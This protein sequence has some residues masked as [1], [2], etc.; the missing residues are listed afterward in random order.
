MHTHNV[1]VD[2]IMVKWRVNAWRNVRNQGQKLRNHTPPLPSLLPTQPTMQSATTTHSNDPA[3]QTLDGPLTSNNVKLVVPQSSAIPIKPSANAH[4]CV[5]PSGSYRILQRNSNVP[6]SSA[7]ANAIVHSPLPAGSHLDSLP[8]PQPF[9]SPLNPSLTFAAL[10]TAPVHSPT[11]S[12]AIAAG[13]GASPGP[14]PSPP[15]QEP[16]LFVPLNPVVLTM[17]FNASTG[18][19]DESG[20]ML[21]VQGLSDSMKA[22][23]GPSDR[24]LRTLLDN[25]AS[26]SP[27]NAEATNVSSTPAHAIQ[28]TNV[29]EHKVSSDQLALRGVTEEVVNRGE[30]RAQG[31]GGVVGGLDLLAEAVAQA[32]RL[33]PKRKGVLVPMKRKMD[34]VGLGEGSQSRETPGRGKRSRGKQVRLGG[35]NSRSLEMSARKRERLV[36]A[37]RGKLVS[38]EAGRAIGV[39]CV[40]EL[41]VKGKGR[42]R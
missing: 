22:F 15:S 42:A 6:G 5:P 3:L 26:V 13:S 29:R 17:R 35:E 11:S 1:Q 18:N 33:E 31:R 4:L 38:D 2:P 37:R 34:A 23:K 30:I 40:D 28:T 24:A 7:D 20:G 39:W 25:R 8:N 12:Q 19:L 16:S 27:P 41:D 9:T 14:I 10:A 21:V 36:G 32:K